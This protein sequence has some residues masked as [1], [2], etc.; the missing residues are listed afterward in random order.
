MKRIYLAGPDVFF[1]NPKAVGQELKALCAEFGYEGVF[2][3]DAEIGLEPKDKP[4]EV[5]RKI[6]FGNVYLI[7]S[8]DAVLAN[9]R[10]WRGPS[11]DV[12]TAWEMGYAYSRGKTIVGHTTDLRRYHERVAAMP[13]IQDNHMVENF[14][15]VDN[16]MLDNSAMKIFETAREAL[17]FLKTFPV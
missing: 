13:S 8:A 3:L 4:E 6:F 11:M 17:A 14:N 15:L 1:E 10:P 7:N 5:G 12:G 2:P 16:L 9:M